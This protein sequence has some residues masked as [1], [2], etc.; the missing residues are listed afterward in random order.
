VFSPDGMMLATG[1]ADTTARLW[2][3]LSGK[4]LATLEG[5]SQGVLSLSFSPDGARLATASEDGT[6]K[7][8]D[9]SY[10]RGEES[11]R[12]PLMTFKDVRVGPAFAV[13]FSPD[14]QAMATGNVDGTVLIRFAATPDLIARRSEPENTPSKKGRSLK[15]IFFRNETRAP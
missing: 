1:S 8:W 9:T 3:S 6:V 14:G 5:H 2:D 4:L 15:A 11:I 12:H 7:L 10:E 13:A